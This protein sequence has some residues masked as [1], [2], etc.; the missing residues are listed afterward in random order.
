ML[1]Q[2]IMSYLWNYD[3][4][5]EAE[6]KPSCRFS[7]MR[8]QIDTTEENAHGVK[9][10]LCLCCDISLRSHCWCKLWSI[11]VKTTQSNKMVQLL[12]PFQ[13]HTHGRVYLTAQCYK[14]FQSMNKQLKF[15]TKNVPGLITVVIVTTATIHNKIILFVSLLQS[16]RRERQ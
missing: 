15:Q 9:H 12:F 2:K 1:V 16:R 11:R 3:V 7:K 5:L 4:P 14:W 6:R 8:L 13:H 10:E